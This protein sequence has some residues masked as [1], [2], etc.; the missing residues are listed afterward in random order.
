MTRRCLFRTIGTVAIW[1]VAAITAHAHRMD[2]QCFVRPFW[3]VQVEAWYETGDPPRGARVQVFRADN[4]LLVEGRLDDNGVF[5]FSFREAEN[6]K[7]VVS[8]TGHRAEATVSSEILARQL[9]LTCVTC[10]AGEAPPFLIAPLLA[11]P[12]PG[13]APIE[14]AM[15]A[16]PLRGRVSRFPTL[17]MLAGVSILLAV[18]VFFRRRSRR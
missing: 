8:S 4:S 3:Q 1:L 10:L 6:L 11:P 18:A 12:A 15:H 9:A 16:P 13:D 17:G 7:V 2:A 14:T 5:A